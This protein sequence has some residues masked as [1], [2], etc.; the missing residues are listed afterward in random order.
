MVST[1]VI[2]FALAHQLF[3]KT[4]PRDARAGGGAVVPLVHA[5]RRPAAGA[6]RSTLQKPC[7]PYYRLR[8]SPPAAAGLEVARLDCADGAG[9]GEDDPQISS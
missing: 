7:L 3:V 2:S 1:S 6:V 9:G 5:L 4:P 8:S